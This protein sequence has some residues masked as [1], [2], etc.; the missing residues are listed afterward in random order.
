VG[1]VFRTV[2]ALRVV[3]EPALRLIQG[4]RR[5]GDRAGLPRGR[6][7]QRSAGTLVQARAVLVEEREGAGT[8][9]N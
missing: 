2:T 8:R 6:S 1:A 9:Q 4:P 5:H 7:A 3:M